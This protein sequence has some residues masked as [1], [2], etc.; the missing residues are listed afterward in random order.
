M[1]FKCDELILGKTDADSR[2]LT[3]NAGRPICCKVSLVI[4][5]EKA[6][7]APRAITAQQNIQTAMVMGWQNASECSGRIGSG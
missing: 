5:V 6:R 7:S 2:A 4:A 1:D 3:I